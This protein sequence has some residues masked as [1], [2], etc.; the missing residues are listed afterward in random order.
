MRSNNSGGKFEVVMMLDPDMLRIW[1]LLTELEERARIFTNTETFF[2]PW[3]KNAYTN[4]EAA[5][6]QL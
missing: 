4:E 1:G 3:V 6:I 5:V 2:L